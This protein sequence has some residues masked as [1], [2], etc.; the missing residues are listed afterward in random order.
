MT[1]YHDLVFGNKL[2]SGRRRYFL[3]YVQN[4]PLPDIQ[5]AESCDIIDTVKKINGTDDEN[6]IG[7]LCRYQ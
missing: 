7:K 4:Y 2:Y 6:K 5:T 1:K 3:Q